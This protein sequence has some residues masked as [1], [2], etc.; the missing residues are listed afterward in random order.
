MKKMSFQHF[1]DVDKHDEPALKTVPE[2]RHFKTKMEFDQAV[3]R[4]FIVH[5]N[6][7]TRKGKIFLVGLSHGSSPSGPYAY[8]LRHYAEL[9]HP[10]KIRYTFVNSPMK[11]QRG[12]KNVVD[13]GT[14]LGAL[15]TRGYIS[16]ENILGTTLNRDSMEAYMADMETK[17]VKYLAKHHKSGLDYV[18]LSCDPTGRVGAIS[19]GSVAFDK[20]TVGCLVQ[21]R[22]EKEMTITPWFLNQSKRIAFLATKADKRRALAWLYDRWAQPDDS[23][24]FLRYMPE[25]EHRMT[26]FMDNQALTWPQIKVIRST[27]YGDST[28]RLDLQH[29]YDSQAQKKLPV[30][31]MIHGFFGLNSFDG[32]LTSLSSH[33]Y[34]GVAMHYGSIPTDLPKEDYSRHVELNIDAVVAFFG[35]RGHPV[36]ILDHSMANLYFLMIDRDWD[37]LPGIRKYLRGRIGVNPYFGEEAKHALLGFMDNVILPSH[38]NLFEKTV[39]LSARGIIPFDS[40]AGVRKRGIDLTEWI[41]NREKASINRVWIPIKERIFDLLTNIGSLPHLDRVP[42]MRALDRLPAKVFAIQV[43]SA[44]TESMKFDDQVGLHQPKKTGF[45][46]LI[47]KSELDPVAKYVPRLYED[48]TVGTLDVTNYK[49]KDPF[50][51]HLYYMMHPLTTVRIIDE[52]VTEVEKSVELVRQ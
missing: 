16:P 42:V 12:L 19:R 39:F 17:L 27:P 38:Q 13:A 41:I 2:T 33:K 31:L 30:I 11:T 52:F 37:K 34:I 9:R 7:V 50:R 5:A 24:G 48:S 36:Y 14:F 35:K 8:I 21:D 1:E 47:L 3:G 26:V 49:E 51:E 23:P 46:V 44:L 29:P 25:I 18:F 15:K 40:K 28:I 4:D 22:G 32:L 45:P 10:E 6:K 20:Q 43:Y